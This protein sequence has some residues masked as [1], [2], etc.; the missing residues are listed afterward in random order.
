MFPETADPPP[1]CRY[2]SE[3][4]RSLDRRQWPAARR[5]LD[6]HA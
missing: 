4:D 1:G 5:S 6:A 2:G 3:V